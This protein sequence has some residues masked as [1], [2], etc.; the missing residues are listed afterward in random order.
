MAWVKQ[1]CD[2][3]GLNENQISK[4]SGINRSSINTNKKKNTSIKKVKSENL[5]KLSKALGTTMDNLYDWYE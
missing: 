3:Y 1:V 4:V 2:D 5:K